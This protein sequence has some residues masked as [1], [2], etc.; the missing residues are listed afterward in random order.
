MPGTTAS[1]VPL[2]GNARRSGTRSIL[3]GW[4]FAFLLFATVFQSSAQDAAKFTRVEDIIYGRK[5]GVAL[6]MDMLRPAEPNGLGVVFIVSGGWYSAKRAINPTFLNGF[7]ERGY[8]VFAVL[9]GSQPKFQIPGIDKDIHRAV[10][11]IRHNAKKF[12]VDPERLGV[13]GASAGGHLSLLLATRGDVGKA[14]A[15]DPVDRESSAVQAV[16][17]FFPPTDFLNYG[18]S[19][20]DAVGVGTLADYNAAFGP[21]IRTAQGRKLLG[22][23]ISPINFV[24][25]KTPPILIVHGDA[26]VLVP[27]Q[28]A[29]SFLKKCEEDKVPTMLI[30]RE[31][32]GH[33]WPGM[34]KE[35]ALMAGWFD[36]HLKTSPKDLDRSPTI[37]PSKRET[38]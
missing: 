36:Q 11:F 4:T 6:T 5:H 7:I 3:P 10:R 8:T 28:Q 24:S 32:K 25:G 38:D 22:R 33:G 13:S 31:G 16:A 2:P 20:E 15:K 12:G 21:M 9:H 26:D 23:A 29:E 27:I 18:K 14:D 37:R 34:E 19:G 30:R 35:M 1:T 17:C